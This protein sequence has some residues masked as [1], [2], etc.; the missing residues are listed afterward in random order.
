MRALIRGPIPRS[1]FGYDE[2]VG[3]SCTTDFINSIK[4]QCC[5]V[6]DL[7]MRA[8]ANDISSFTAREALLRLG[9]DQV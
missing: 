5:R 9:G 2:L 4:M 8:N 6:V 1:I 7:V 3:G